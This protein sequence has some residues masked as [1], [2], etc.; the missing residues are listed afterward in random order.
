MPAPAE[1]RVS[2]R[3]GSTSPRQ[4]IWAIAIRRRCGG[5]VRRAPR[6]DPTWRNFYLTG[7]QELRH[8]ITPPAIDLGGGLAS[9]L[10]VEQLFDTLAI[11]VDGP[12]AATEAMTIDWKFTDL[13]HTIRTQL[14]NG[15]LIQTMDPKSLGR[16][17]LSLTLTKAQLLVLMTGGNANELQHSGDL[18]TLAKL[19]ALLDQPDP[20]FP[21]VSP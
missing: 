19:L 1:W 16:V 20:A 15:V 10:T 14:S 13:G 7:A 17:D 2:G 18:T 4:G 5:S 21:I 12:R 8:G 6:S 11:R 9:A 3:R